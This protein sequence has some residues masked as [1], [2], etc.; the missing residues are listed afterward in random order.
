MNLGNK[1]AMQYEKKTQ[2]LDAFEVMM[3]LKLGS[4]IV[5]VLLFSLT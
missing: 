3:C 2:Q 1:L 4:V 5:L